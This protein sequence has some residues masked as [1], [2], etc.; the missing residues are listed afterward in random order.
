M[1]HP[2]RLLRP[3]CLATALVFVLG[4]VPASSAPRGDEATALRDSLQRKL[5]AL[6]EEAGCP[7]IV[8]GVTLGDGT[9]YAL[10]SGVA[11]EDSGERLTP[12]H[13][14][15]AGSTGKL[16]FAAIALQLVESG[17]LDLDTKAATHLDS[18][19]WYPRLPNHADITLRQLLNHT[20][21][22]VRYELH[23]RFLETLAADPLR[24]FT[25]AERVECLFDSPAPFAAG[26]RFEYSDTNYIVLGAILER[27]LEQDAYA[28]IAAGV[29]KPL[30]LDGIVPARGTTIERLAQGHPAAD[31]PFTGGAK[32]L[33]DGALTLNPQFEWAGGGFA[34]TAGDLARLVHHQFGAGGIGATLRA[35]V[36]DGVDA[37]QLGLGT[38]YGLCCIVKTGPLGQTLG[39]AGFFPG[40]V[41]DARWFADSK[42]AVAVQVNTSDFTRLGKGTGWMLHELART[43]IDAA[44]PSAK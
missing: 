40:Y 28:A 39:H 20:S 11:D 6:R 12:E 7:G 24:E 43:A 22:L 32:L 27:V 42:I 26:E 15:L 17:R 33:R 35:Q 31:D 18:T 19:P 16:L 10:A 29:T 4:S 1:H 30:H 14:M 21:G 41:S 8:A 44:G 13:R 25:I 9:T 37:P 3:L 34:T 2:L 23:P 36:V 5:D 38:R